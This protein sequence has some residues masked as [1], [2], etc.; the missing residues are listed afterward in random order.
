MLLLA[1]FSIIVD[2]H[3][4]L[5]GLEIHSAKTVEVDSI[6]IQIHD[7]VRGKSNNGLLMAKMDPCVKFVRKLD[8][9]L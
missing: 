2:L 8:T 5:M 7:L 4:V 1:A 3:H 9:R 6:N